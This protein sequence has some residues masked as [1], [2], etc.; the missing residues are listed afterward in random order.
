MSQMKAAAPCVCVCVCVLIPLWS[1]PAPLTYLGNFSWIDSYTHVHTVL[2]QRQ[3]LQISEG[4]S[5][6]L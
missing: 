5:I 3:S 1:A 4:L 2:S 6:L